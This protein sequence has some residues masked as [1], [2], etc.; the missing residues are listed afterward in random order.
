MAENK[1]IVCPFGRLGRCY[2]LDPKLYRNYKWFTRVC[3]GVICIFAALQFLVKGDHLA[4]VWWPHDFP[5]EVAIAMCLVLMIGQMSIATRGQVV[6]AAEAETALA[7]TVKPR[8][9]HQLYRVLIFVGSLLLLVLIIGVI[10]YQMK[11]AQPIQT[12]EAL[13]LALALAGLTYV[14]QTRRH[15][16]GDQ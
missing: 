8:S 10:I 1:T 13:I 6:S 4:S 14:Y 16:K 15:H 11:V 9:V 7:A 12:I 3:L 2:R 5:F